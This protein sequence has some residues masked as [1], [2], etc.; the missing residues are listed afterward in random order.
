MKL[1]GPAPS[2]R[3]ILNPHD[4]Q[5]VVG[6]IFP[7]ELAPAAR[8]IAEATIPEVE[9]KAREWWD[10]ETRRVVNEFIYGRPGASEPVGILHAHNIERRKA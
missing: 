1:Q 7:P 5:V 4:M 9:R 3:Y 8:L 2:F 10:A 6:G